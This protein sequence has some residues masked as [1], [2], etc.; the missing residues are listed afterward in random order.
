MTYNNTTN[1]SKAHLGS[2]LRP[3]CYP[4]TPS[5]CSCWHCKICRGKSLFRDRWKCREKPE[6]LNSVA[7]VMARDILLLLAL[8]RNRMPPDLRVRRG[9][10]P[11]PPRLTSVLESQTWLKPHH[12]CPPHCSHWHRPVEASA[13]FARLEVCGEEVRG[14]YQSQLY[15]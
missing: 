5:N 7:I 10:R 8:F 3:A 15:L 13:H 11:G 12:C 9:P 2:S 1:G 14:R 4:Q 6:F